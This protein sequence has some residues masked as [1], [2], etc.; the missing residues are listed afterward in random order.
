MTAHARS[1]DTPSEVGELADIVEYSNDAIIGKTLD[2]IITTWNRAAETVFGYSPAQIIGRSHDLIVPAD[3]AGATHDLLARISAGQQVGHLETICVRK[4]GALFPASLTVLAIFDADGEVV[5]AST[6]VRDDTARVDAHEAA[7]AMIEASLDSLVAISPEGLITDVNEAT[8]KITGIPRQELIGTPFSDCFTEPQKAEEIYRKVFVEGMAGEYPLTI[9]HRDGSISEVLYNASIHRGARGKTLAVFAAARD[10]TELNEAQT[11]ARSM[12]ESSLDSMVAISP[13]GRI[14]DLNEATVQI[15]GVPRQELIGSAFSDYFTDPQK[16]N[17]IYERVFAQGTTVDYPLTMHHRD[18]TLTEVLYN[19]S[20][21]HNAAGDMAGVFAA[22]RDV[23][24]QL[25]AQKQTVEQQA[26]A[27][28][29]LAELEKFHRLAVG[30]ELK[31]AEL[32]KEIE[33]LR[34]SLPAEEAEQNYQR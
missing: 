18:G 21:Y 17:E 9:R 25:Q 5:G 33:N 13:E 7:R 26:M 12:I 4:D 1:E 27:L 8:V 11:A 3:Q 6:V 31:M 2:G 23:T 19:A 28:E 34:A 24:T 29:R 10:M 30:R 16:A 20:I 14:T 32:K 22:A 15:T